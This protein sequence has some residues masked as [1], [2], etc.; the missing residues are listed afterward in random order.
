MNKD[1]QDKDKADLMTQ[2]ENM[3]QELRNIQ[4]TQPPKSGKS[5]KIDE[6][7]EEYDDEL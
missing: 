5:S 2:F 3:Q 1:K 6:E 4:H 7:P